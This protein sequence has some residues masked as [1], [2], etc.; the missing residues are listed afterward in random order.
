MRRVALLCGA[1]SVRAF[2]PGRHASARVPMR[3]MATTMGTTT[4]D[5]ATLQ[6]VEMD[7][8]IKFKDGGAV[9]DP[10]PLFDQGKISFV[11]D[12]GNY[13]PGIHEAASTLEIGEKT[14]LTLPAEKA[15]GPD[16]PEMRAT[17]PLAAAP[18]GVQLGDVLQVSTGQKVRVT[19][20]TK[21]SLTIDGNAPHA[22]KELELE[23][24]VLRRGALGES[25]VAVMDVAGGCFWGMELAF[26]RAAGVVGT[27]V[28]YTHGEKAN[29]TYNEVCSGATGHTEAVRIY[30][31][32]EQTTPAELL[33]V[34][35]G[36][37]DPTQLNRQGNDRGT[38]YRGGIYYHTEEQKEAAEAAI[39]AQ[40]K[41]Y[42]DQEV[43]TELKPAADSDFWHAEDYHQQYLQKG[44]QDACKTATETIRCYG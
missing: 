1:A 44:G 34:F 10:A 37:H 28:G 19:E 33:D 41:V 32:E 23:A 17:A 9:V 42:G 13:L 11:V 16:I 27:A 40:Q 26:Q 20:I 24:T 31:D 38:Q 15:F 35:F 22:G 8:A 43:V 3:M 18:P 29:P 5:P 25:G 4:V 7:Y 6:V 12:H 21:D 30:Y 39:A 36:R 14:T 2:T